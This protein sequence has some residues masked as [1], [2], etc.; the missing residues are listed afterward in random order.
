MDRIV[1]TYGAVI[2]AF[3]AGL[4]SFLGLIIAKENKVSEFRQ[5]WIDALRA[6][7]ARFSAAVSLLAQA[8]VRWEQDD[9][10]TGW[11]ELLK[12]IQPQLD[13]ALSAQTSIL[14]R[15]NPYDL[16]AGHKPLVDAV[17]RI[18]T[19]L[20]ESKYDEAKAA[21]YDLHVVAAPVLKHEWERVKSGERF[22]QAAK[23]GACA[24]VVGSLIALLAY[25][26]GSVGTAQSPTPT[27]RS[28]PRPAAK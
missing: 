23:W 3:V 7:L 20:N 26:L 17:K 6:D 15:L 16:D 10:Q 12:V 13:A 18:R 8:Q 27:P 14:L 4:F 22:Y 5:S 1:S 2:V 25:S 11:Q 28:G 9:P 24:I 21:A 19:L